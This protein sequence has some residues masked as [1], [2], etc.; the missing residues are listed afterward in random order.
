MSSFIVDRYAKS[1]IYPHR[2]KADSGS[3]NTGLAWNTV[4]FSIEWRVV[5]DAT[6]TALSLVE[7]VEGVWGDSHFVERASGNAW[8]ELGMPNIAIQPGK[9]TE[10]RV[11]APGNDY[12][13]GSISATGTTATIT[14]SGDPLPPSIF[15][16][17]FEN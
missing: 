16:N 9:T 11:L 5:G 17:G 14:I 10:V 1:V 3:D 2:I 4:G 7:G 8:Y 6:W 15:R 13:Y 12:R